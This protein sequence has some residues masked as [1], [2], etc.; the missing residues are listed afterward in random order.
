[1]V[2]VD[3]H[4]V[5][6]DTPGNLAQLPFLVGRRLVLG[7][8]P[9][10]NR[11]PLHRKALSPVA[12]QHEPSCAKKRLLFN[13]QNAASKALDFIDVEIVIFGRVF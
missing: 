2:A 4:D 13:T 7:R 9:E 5:V 8:D 1:M 12:P 11:S 6:A 10:I 3:L